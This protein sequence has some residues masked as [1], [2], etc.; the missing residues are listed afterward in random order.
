MTQARLRDRISALVMTG[1]QERISTQLATRPAEESASLMPMIRQL[2]ARYCVKG[3]G[4]PGQRA[5]LWVAGAACQDTAVDVA[6]WL[7]AP[8]LETPSCSA[9][10]VLRVLRGR[11]ADWQRETAHLIA[12]RQPRRVVIR[13]SWRVAYGLT[14]GS[15]APAP[16]VDGFV[17]GWVAEAAAPPDH[18][19]RVLLAR[20]HR[21]TVSPAA[22]SLVE[23]LRHDPCLVQTVPRLFEV[24]R[25]GYRLQSPRDAASGASGTPGAGESWAGALATLADEGRLDRGALIDGCL[26][27]LARGELPVHVRGFIDIHAALAP[28]VRE[29]ADRAPVYVRLLLQSGNAVA[30]FAQRELRRIDEH[31]LLDPGVPLEPSSV[32]LGRPERGLVRGQL[33]WL[34][35]HADRYPDQA[36][37][38]VAV[39]ALALRHES[40]AV[41]ERAAS[42][43]AR[44]ADAAGEGVLNEIRTA[45]R[46]LDVSVRALILPALGVADAPPAQPVDAVP[47]PPPY[48]PAPM[49]DPL[50]TPTAVAE[51]FADVQ[52]AGRIDSPRLERLL[53][54]VVVMAWSDR[55]ALRDALSRHAQGRA[56]GT[57]RPYSPYAYPLQ[58]ALRQLAHV[59]GGGQAPTLV[60]VWGHIR[61]HRIAPNSIPISRVF[62][63]CGRLD[64]APVPC[65]LATPTESSG[66]IDPLVL[67]ERL[68]RYKAA[69]RHPWPLDFEQALWRLPAEIAHEAVVAVRRL[70]SPAGARLARRLAAGAEDGVRGT[71]H[72]HVKSEGG[73]VFA[74]STLGFAVRRVRWRRRLEAARSDLFSCLFRDDPAGVARGKLWE[75][76]AVEH[77]PA[78]APSEPE[79]IA[80]HALPVLK[81]L[82]RNPYR[83][84]ARVLPV[85]AGSAGPLGPAA[86]TALASGL[87][88]LEAED[89]ASATAAVGILAARGL[90]DPAELGRQL[91]AL[92]NQGSAPR[93]RMIS[94]LRDASLAGAHREVWQTLTVLLPGVLAAD[95][96]GDVVDLLVLATECAKRAG[97]RGSFPELDA[98]AAR[99]G[100]KRWLLEARRLRRTLTG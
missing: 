33:A 25:L 87:T 75:L 64:R 47:G 6:R 58:P 88:A 100:A 54:A 70:A 60:R 49:P 62:E 14:A 78:V 50:D 1:E 98:V 95:H 4:N 97:A 72:V 55:S 44:H 17:R 67:I 41:Q 13:P 51:E 94:S 26:S 56:P 92:L 89:R 7:T 40:A 36:G 18:D 31:G 10:A 96:R 43:I 76:D 30:K 52:R 93:E 71:W 99:G 5:A 2:H 79:L 39:A 32:V 27:R 53:A 11:P 24:D 29:G 35:K 69:G 38:V 68:L 82:S 90:L 77:W 48:R 22:G 61:D 57:S 81:Q 19:I 65:L 12:Q 15:G 46:D 73:Q 83:G 8:D 66:L 84:L 59:I 23:R 63:L 37:P 74:R 85:L 91:S 9:L 3:K 80:A 21:R 86:H 45:A 42:L 20:K 16:E 34:D 28:T